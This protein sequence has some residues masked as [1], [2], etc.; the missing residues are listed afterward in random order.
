MSELERAV[1]TVVDQCLGIAEGEEVVVVVDDATRA[2]G[3]GLRDAAAQ[4]GAE[5]VLTVMDPRPRDGA[6]P[7]AAVAEALKAADVFIAPTSRSLS[8]TRARKAASEAAG[9][10]VGRVRGRCCRD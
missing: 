10:R 5:A 6:E 7:P 1:D 9:P 4:R 3:D 8:H 2:I